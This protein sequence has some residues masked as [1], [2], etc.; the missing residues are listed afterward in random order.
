MTS[1]A[2]NLRSRLTNYHAVN[3]TLIFRHF[4]PAKRLR[5][6]FNRI[7][8]TISGSS[9]GKVANALYTDAVH[10]ACVA[11]KDLLRPGLDIT[12]P[13]AVRRSR[14]RYR[15]RPIG[16]TDLRRYTKGIREYVSRIPTL[17]EVDAGGAAR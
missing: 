7:G 13:R 6:M 9:E 1:Q 12:Y 10:V 17:Y 4:H 16:V 8:F 14:S 3:N 2:L 11:A 15:Q 5:I